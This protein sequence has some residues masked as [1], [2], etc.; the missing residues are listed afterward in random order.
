M[1]N[2]RGSSLILVI[3]C[4]AFAGIL[5]TTVLVSATS[6]RDMKLVDEMAKENF[7]QTESGIDL[8]TANLSQMAEKVMGDAYTFVLTHYS[9]DN[10]TVLKT[11]VKEQL[12]FQ[13]TGSAASEGVEVP[14][15]TELLE[16]AEDGTLN[17]TL[18][19]GVDPA[20]YGT[21]LRLLNL[22]GGE[23]LKAVVQGNDIVLKGL[24]IAYQEN[25][26]ETKIKTDVRVK[27]DFT[28][29]D[30]E[31]PV[32][33][34]GNYMDYAIIT[35]KN[36]VIPE[37]E[38]NVSGSVYA[39]DSV[40]ADN[41]G[42]L[43]LAAKHLIA[44]S[45]IRTER[46]GVLGI[47][48]LTGNV[49]I[50]TKNILTVGDRTGATDGQSIQ[51]ENAN[52]YVA[53]DMTVGAENSNIK[54][55]GNYYG[56][57]TVGGGTSLSDS[58][59]IVINSGKSVLNL[60]KLDILWL[61]GRSS[62]EVPNIYGGDKSVSSYRQIMEGETVSYK[63]NQL[64]YLVPG[65]CIKE[66]EHNPLT[67][68]EYDEIQGKGGIAVYV[69]TAA[70]FGTDGKISLAKYVAATPC[71]V[72]P[73]CFLSEDEPLYYV[74]LKFKSSAAAQ[75]YFLDYSR[76]CKSQLDTYAK[77]LELGEVKLPAAEKIQT[78]GAVLRVER[79]DN[80]PR[81]MDVVSGTMDAG[82]ALK[83][84]SE[85]KRKFSGLLSMLDEDFNGVASASLVNNII[86]VSELPSGELHLYFDKEMKKQESA[87]DAGDD[88]YEVIVTNQDLAL[89]SK[90]FK[91]IVIARGKITMQGGKFTG[92]M[93]ATDD[94]TVRGATITGGSSFMKELIDKN[95]SLQ[96]Y[97]KNYPLPSGSGEGDKK[98]EARNIVVT[99]E[100]WEKN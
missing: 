65:E 94:I 96:R 80:I 48:G 34:N 52:C 33:I 46:G 35:D 89:D 77:V 100:N 40:V 69:D 82:E 81:I 14:V 31:T 63:G 17:G 8:F 53:D 9:E 54:I 18:F 95:P 57:T 42:K 29:L 85:F 41:T 98:A 30:V 61:A 10:D 43:I 92:M 1:K 88:G 70:K 3:I 91:G 56:Y 76:S 59:A 11:K 32:T 21:G 44:G 50:W 86:R 7:Y 62:L 22:E 55:T 13:L 97:F 83:K 20:I 75:E 12:F 74:Y 79:V 36:F 73:V 58:S 26:Y 66:Y 45:Q 37:S 6:N 16:K 28:K 23:S 51:I 93:L 2:N 24:S 27:V 60:E 72:V 19:E 4:I 64:A 99:L 49:D 84:Q 47:S 25:G 90:T 67:K 5:G 39:G 38:S 15:K 71:E 68:A 78:N 87:Q